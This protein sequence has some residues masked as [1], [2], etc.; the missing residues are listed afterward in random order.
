MQLDSQHIL[1]SL[2]LTMSEFIQKINNLE[3]INLDPFSSQDTIVVMIDMING[4][5]NTGPLHSDFVQQM[6]P[7]MSIFLDKVIAKNIPIISYR[8]SHPIDTAEFHDY[9][10]HCLA[11]TAE[12]DLVDELHRE[13]LIDVPKNSTNGFL[14][15]NPL[16]LVN[17]PSIKHIIVIGCVTDICVRDFA[18]TMNKHLHEINQKAT[19]YVVENFTDTF[20]IDGVHDRQVEHML[21]MYQMNNSGIEVIRF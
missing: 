7:D 12:S 10:P 1:N 13:V 8:D 20:H 9:P 15:T 18:T 2:T 14:A 16:E 3:P 5:C 21:S 4:F 11:G 6:V 19:V 17:G